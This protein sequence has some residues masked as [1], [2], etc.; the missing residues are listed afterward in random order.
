MTLLGSQ[1]PTNTPS[2]LA[3]NAATVHANPTTVFLPVN[4]GRTPGKRALEARLGRFAAA[5]LVFLSGAAGAGIVA[6]D[7]GAGAHRPRR[8][9]LGGGLEL[10]VLLCAPLLAFEGLEE[11]RRRARRRRLARAGLVFRPGRLHQEEVADGFGVDALHHVFKQR[12]GFLLEL[13]QRVFLAVAAQAD[14]FLEVVERE[15]VG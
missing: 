3:N 10:Q 4:R 11:R 6:A 15:Q 14:A 9:G 2:L 8:F 5:F 1:A 12:E 13:H 7:L